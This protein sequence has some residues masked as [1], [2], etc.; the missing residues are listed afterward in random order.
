MNQHYSTVPALVKLGSF[1]RE[2]V[3]YRTAGGNALKSVPVSFSAFDEVLLRATAENAWFTE[4]EILFALHS[5]AGNLREETLRGW[6][7]RYALPAQ[8]PLTVALI[9]AGNIPLVGFHDFLSVL[10]CGHKALVKCSA[11]D[12]RLLPFLAQK[13]MEYDPDLKGCM[14]FTTGQLGSFD[15]V[16]ATGSNNTSRYFEYYF[17]DKP[18]IIRKNRNSVAVLNGKETQADLSGLAT[19][20][21]RYFGMGCRSVSKLYVPGNYD[22]SDL[23]KAFYEFR[24]VINHHKYSNN[25]DYNKAVYLMSGSKMLDNDFLLLKEDTGFG[26]PIGTLFYEHYQSEEALKRVLEQNNENIQ[27]LVGHEA[28]PGAIPFGKAQK[29]DLSDYADGVDTVEFLLK[30]SIK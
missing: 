4:S 12:Q 20:V 11:K 24:D 27:C 28:I 22:F 9:M 5:W 1:L 18:H 23:F 16:I 2:Y 13:L 15:A 30:N 26:S 10:V 21:F 25:Y 8:K 17:A 29:P 14:E 3:T 6:L 19:D 7:E